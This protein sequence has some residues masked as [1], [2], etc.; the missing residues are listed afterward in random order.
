V[1]WSLIAPSVM[2][3]DLNLKN[4]PLHY[5]RGLSEEK[6]WQTAITDSGCISIPG[7]VRCTFRESLAVMCQAGKTGK[8]Q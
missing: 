3:I 7:T 6:T 2:Q 8:M 4:I 1:F 5:H